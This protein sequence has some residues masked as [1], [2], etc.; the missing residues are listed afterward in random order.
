M[1]NNGPLRSRLLESKWTIEDDKDDL[2]SSISFGWSSG[3]LVGWIIVY[4]LVV[5]HSNRVEFIRI[6]Q[7]QWSWSPNGKG[8]EIVN[9]NSINLGF[10]PEH[11]G[12]CD[13]KMDQPQ[14]V[15]VFLLQKR[16]SLKAVSI[17]RWSIRLI[18]V[19]LTNGCSPS[20][21]IV[22]HLW[23]NL[24]LRASIDGCMHGLSGLHP[25]CIHSGQQ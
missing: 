23:L 22:H 4:P 21:T 3:R 6:C 9:S 18:I 2:N 24:T 14:K 25:E 17:F 20:R 10:P 13:E 16:I 15:C 11:R 1:I 19:A 12:G 7:V 8:D 5:V